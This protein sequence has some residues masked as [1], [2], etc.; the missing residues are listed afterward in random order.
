MGQD[1]KDVTTTKLFFFGNRQQ[2]NL[3]LIL[4]N[5]GVELVAQL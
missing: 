5:G 3:C 4:C 1:C 2:L